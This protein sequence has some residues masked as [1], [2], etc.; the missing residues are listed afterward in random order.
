MAAEVDLYPAVERWVKRRFGCF[1]T[2]TNTGIR[3]GRIDVVGV[4]DTGGVF[5]GSTELVSVEVKAGRQPFATAAGQAH[6][7]SVYA[8]RCYLADVREGRERFSQDELDIAAAL[9]IG[10][11]AIRP[12]GIEEVLTAPIGQ[13]IDRLQ[14]QVLAQLGHGVCTICGSVFALGTGRGSWSRMRRQNQQGTALPKAVAEE[15]GLVY[16]LEEVGVRSGKVTVDG[17]VYHRRYVCPD[18]AWGLFASQL[19]ADGE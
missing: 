10:L 6:G 5:T 18:C 14:L 2:G 11:L 15:K 12:R 1:A 7:Y 8:E 17:Y 3:Y 13:P 19:P 4:R 9:G 16:W